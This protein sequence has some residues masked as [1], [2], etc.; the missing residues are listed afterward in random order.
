MIPDKLLAFSAPVG[1]H[2]FNEYSVNDYA[3]EFA[4]LGVTAIVRLNEST[5]NEKEF[6]SQGFNHYDLFFLDGSCPSIEIVNRFISI[7]DRERR[8]AVHCKAGLG[9]TGSLIGCYAIRKHGFSPEDFIGWIRMCRPGS[10]LGP[11]QQF[12]VDFARGHVKLNYD[13]QGQYGQAERL[14]RAKQTFVAPSGQ[15]RPRSALKEP[16]YKVTPYRTNYEEYRRN[17]LC[18]APVHRYN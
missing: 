8:V 6:T 13:V 18:Y 10:V 3:R 16:D 9:R 17:Y 4:C 15:E 7:C 1:S 12:L 11:Q 14:I 2:G 5:Y